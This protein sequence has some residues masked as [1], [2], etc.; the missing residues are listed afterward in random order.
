MC[1]KDCKDR[2]AIT[3]VGKADGEHGERLSGRTEY[4]EHTG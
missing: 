4:R 3:V 1:L 2:G